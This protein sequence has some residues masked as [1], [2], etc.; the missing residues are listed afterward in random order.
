MLPILGASPIGYTAGA[1]SCSF[2]LLL[3]YYYSCY[4]MTA[5]TPPPILHEHHERKI[6]V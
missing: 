3:L 5:M 4:C 6:K 1:D 2:P